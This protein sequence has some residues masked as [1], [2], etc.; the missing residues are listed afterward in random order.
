MAL[1]I[2][3]H[4][5]YGQKVDVYS[6][7]LVLWESVAGTIPYKEMNPIQ[8]AFVVVSKNLRHLIPENC[9]PAMKV[10]I[11]QCCLQPKKRHWK[12]VEVLET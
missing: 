5:L 9:S 1:E 6:F 10:L 8:A 11:E 4:K 7:G 3:K 12:I 2:I